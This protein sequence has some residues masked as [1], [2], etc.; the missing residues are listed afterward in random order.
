M[1]TVTRE[2]IGTLHDKITVKLAKEDYMSSFEK[3]LKQYAKNAAIPGFRKGNVPTALLRKMYGQSVF[4]DEV[5]RVAGRQL[6]DYL[7]GENLAIF[8]QPLILPNPDGYTMDMNSP[9]DVDFFFEIGLKPNVD[10]K[11]VI[12]NTT[13]NRYKIDVTDKMLDDEM[14]RIARRSGK[15]DEQTEVTDKESIIYSTYEACDADGN[16]T[17]ATDKIED[18]EALG[19]MPAKLQEMLSGKQPG[20]TAVIRPA[21]VCSAEELE[22]FLK[23]PL[24]AGS[25]TAENHYK[26]TL[27]KV[28]HL[29]PAEM[30][31]ELYEKV[32]PGRTINSETEFRDLVR[33]ELNKE[34]AR[35]ASERLQNEIFELLVHNTPI[36]LPVPFLKRWMMEGQ[37]KPKSADEVENEFPGFDHQL[38][39]QL[40]TEKI[41]QESGIQ[42]SLDEVKQNIKA[43]VMSY[44]GI[45][46]EEDAPWMES[47]MTKIMKEE[48]MLDET[49][50][51]LLTGKIFEHLETMVKTTETP[52]DEEAFF[53]L[54]DAHSMHHH[55][56]HAHHH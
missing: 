35:L 53:K 7:R 1:A 28:G 15:V 19:K 24:K 34:F 44:F 41:M 26:F 47:Y 46:S 17:N 48:K 39:W 54:A 55:H 16:V 52:I 31:V 2:N 49:Y 20:F 14:E 36:E 50:R 3:S 42:V 45:E 11:P 40:I 13:L 23:D 37:E 12:D 6:E 10:I 29:I 30:G 22:G 18:T 43:Q 8:A 9:A 21:D 56:D 32:F 51:R 27:T 33:A 4:N 38:R 5:V 25:E